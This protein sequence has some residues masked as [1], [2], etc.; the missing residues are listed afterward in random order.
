MTRIGAV[1]A[2][3]V[4]AV[5]GFGVYEAF[6]PRT[7]TLRWD[8]DYE[9][10]PPCNSS[11]APNSPGRR[12]ILGFKVFLGKPTSRSGQQFV[13]NR[14]DQSGQIISKGITWTMPVRPFGNTQFCVVSVATDGS[15]QTVESAPIC[16][17]R[18]VLPFGLG[19]K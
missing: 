13:L 8:Q 16:T 11:G 6:H 3:L 19:R 18:R 7:A 12:C 4:L 17:T 2:L 15:P 14:F 1:I 9:K 5:L 10:D